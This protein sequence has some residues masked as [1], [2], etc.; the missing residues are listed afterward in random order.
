MDHTLLR[1]FKLRTISTLINF[2]T[3]NKLYLNCV[4][5][6]YLKKSRIIILATTKVKK[7]KK[8]NKKDRIINFN[9]S[10]QRKEKKKKK[11]NNKKKEFVLNKISNDVHNYCIVRKSS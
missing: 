3:A 8:T 7:K 9:K 4:E 11:E 10:P 5:L 1:V 6:L 2:Y